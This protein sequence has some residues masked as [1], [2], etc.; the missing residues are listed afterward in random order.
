MTGLEGI[1]LEVTAKASITISNKAGKH[2][3]TFV[4][5]CF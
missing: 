3:M 5:Y 4:L 1:A 2:R